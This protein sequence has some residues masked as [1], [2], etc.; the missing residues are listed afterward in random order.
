M[1]KEYTT[2][3]SEAKA[4]FE[5][6]KSRFISYIYPITDEAQAI[7]FIAKRKSEYY[8]ASH[9][10]HAY[11]LREGNIKRYSDDGEP[12]GTAGIPVL[13]VIEK[14]GL[15]DVVITV[16]RYFGGTKLGGG[17]LVRA[18]SHSASL[19]IEAAEKTTLTECVVI[20]MDLD[21]SQ[22]G[23][24]NNILPNYAHKVIETDYGVII[25]MKVMLSLNKLD[26]FNK[27]LTDRTS[28]T[29]FPRELER[30]LSDIN[31]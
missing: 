10:V 24:I 18:Y 20:E 11:L 12:Q 15:S 6:K 21:Y 16:T 13:D 27:K 26:D 19:V 22:Y 30:V 17:G 7:E 28:G 4:E 2:V 31:R 3:V 1:L 14:T 5:E 29:V 23:V 25:K 8:N 9:T